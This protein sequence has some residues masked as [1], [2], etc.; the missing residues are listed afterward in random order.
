MATTNKI[1]YPST[2]TVALTISLASL[3]D[4][5]TNGIAGRT[6]TA[7]DNTTNLDQDALLSGYIKTGTSPTAGRTIEI[8]LYAPVSIASGTPT[9]PDSVTGTDAAKTFTSR[10]ILQYG[11]RLAATLVVDATTGNVYPIAPISVASFYGYVLPPFWG[12]FVLNRTAVALDSTGGN[13]ALTYERI[14][15]QGV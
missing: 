8:W 6:S 2:S 12:A 1:F 5:N 10:N 14:Q 13:H 7:V 9:Y 3:A 4:D 15:S 11:L